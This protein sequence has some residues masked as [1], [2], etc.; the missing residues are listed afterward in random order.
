MPRRILFI[1]A[2]MIVSALFAQ[3][4]LYADEPRLPEKYLLNYPVAQQFCPPVES[5]WDDV[6]NT[7][8][9]IRGRMIRHPLGGG[10]GLPVIDM[11]GDKHLL[12][13]GA[14]VS[15]HRPVAVYAIANGV[16]R[17]STGGPLPADAQNR[18]PTD[19]DAAGLRPPGTL[20]DKPAVAPNT[21]KPAG[22]PAA[23][24]PPTAPL[25]WGNLIVIEHKL[26]DGSYMTSI[27]GH[28]AN[29]RLVAAGDVVQAGQVI[30]TVAKSKLENGGYDPHLHFAIR[31]GRMF[32]PGR[33]L[34]DV[35]MDGQQTAV[36]LVDLNETEAE[37][38][39]PE[40]APPNLHIG[41]PGKAISITT[42]D[43]KHFMPAV[44]LTY[45]PPQGFPII[46]YALTTDGFRDPTAFLREMRA[47]T[48]PAPFGRFPQ[49][50]ATAAKSR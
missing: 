42:R 23:G 24:K 27:Y 36:K 25:G 3:P 50:T 41:L 17:I 9:N 35:R 30:G 39:L 34:F 10:F 14:D 32:E 21:D 43:G 13:L 2:A 12:H 1:C 18:K 6:S 8:Q 7:I 22:A 47:D 31:E 11:V 4:S 45:L 46:G 48:Q 49:L 44:A 26:P 20:L 28:L 16:V 40:S 15:W 5:F 38:E 29:R 19:K 37:V 33:E